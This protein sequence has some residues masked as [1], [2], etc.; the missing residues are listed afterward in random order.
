MFLKNL[1]AFFLLLIPFLTNAQGRLML[2]GGGSETDGGWSDT[3]YQWMVD[4]AA[5]KKIAIISYA[6]ADQWL[7]NYFKK[8]GASEANNIKIA[9]RAAAESGT[10]YT[11]LTAYDALFFKGGD[12]LKYYEYYKN[13]PVQQAIEDIYENGG[14]IGGTS[15]GMAILSRVMFTAEEGS[16]FPIDAL[17]NINSRFITLAND[18]LPFYEN[19]IFDTHFIERG[20]T[21]RVIG[22]MANWFDE[23]EELINAI[24]VDDRTAFCIDAQGQG[25]VYGTGAASVY[26]PKQFTITNNQLTD[27][28]VKAMQLTHGQTFDLVNKTQVSVAFAEVSSPQL[29][30]TYYNVFATGTLG[31][32]QNKPL[33]QDALT[34]AGNASE[35]IIVTD[36]P[37]GIAKS[38]Y[39]YFETELALDVQMVGTSNEFNSPDSSNLRNKI[40]AAA[41]VL[42]IDAN[43]VEDFLEGGKTGELIKTHVKRN[44][45]TSVF[46]GKLAEKI[47]QTYCTNIYSDPLNAYYD[48][49]EF[50]A[51]LNMLPQAFITTNSFK[52]DEKDYYENIASVL[53]DQLLT[54][55]LAY[56]VYLPENSYLKYVISASDEL[57]LSTHGGPSAVLVMNSGTRYQRTSQTVSGNTSRTQYGFDSLQYRMTKASAYKLM[58]VTA[59]S[60][61]EYTLE[62]EIILSAKSII[63]NKLI[64]QANPVGASLVFQQ[65]L[66]EQHRL[67]IIDQSGKTVWN[68]VLEQHVVEVNI[69]TL[70]SGLYVIKLQNEV[71]NE[72]YLSKIVKR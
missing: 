19:Y 54:A 53:V 4:N 64:L 33:L 62:E 23:E 26:L 34:A 20:R 50:A 40:R 31:L 15:A 63:S 27:S 25:T 5:N 44:L 59:Q 41:L 24:G 29:Q 52:L 71:D 38:Y 9:S 14:V 69:N 13:T 7:P 32:Q 6:D 1:F 56:G 60:Q 22:F 42:F 8:L 51:G 12:Q 49:L 35:L 37:Q 68:K 65:P 55:S 18:F 28:D 21:A 39:N 3:P 67:T 10:I 61:E 46:I 43:A 17:E 2:V 45:I 66:K 48:D 16:A 70:K 36:N 57:N 30:N 72:V 11:E 47:G 58:E